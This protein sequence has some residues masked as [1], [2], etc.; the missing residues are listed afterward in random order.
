MRNKKI[1]LKGIHTCMHIVLFSCFISLLH[2]F[3]SN[4]LSKQFV[5]VFFPSR[6]EAVKDDKVKYKEKE[7]NI[8]FGSCVKL[9]QGVFFF[10]CIA[11]L[12]AA[13]EVIVL[14]AVRTKRNS[15]WHFLVMEDGVLRLLSANVLRPTKWIASSI[16]RKEIKT[17][18]PTSIR[19]QTIMSALDGKDELHEEKLVNNSDNSETGTVS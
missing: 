12:N 4:F 6:T 11:I 17:A 10:G 5:C 7:Y 18:F 14:E 19:S 9:A 15:K 8:T 13:K 2:N 3:V 1:Q 16:K